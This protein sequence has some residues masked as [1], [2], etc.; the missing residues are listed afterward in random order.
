MNCRRHIPGEEKR[1][2]GSAEEDADDGE[3]DEGSEEEGGDE[4][5]ALFR[6]RMEGFDRELVEQDEREEDDRQRDESVREECVPC[7]QPG[8]PIQDEFIDQHPE[9]CGDDRNTDGE[10]GQ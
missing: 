7:R 3:D 4:K 2:A 10:Q 1:H 9:R 5:H 6:I 8:A